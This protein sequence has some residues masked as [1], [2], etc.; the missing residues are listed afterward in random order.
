MVI[1]YVLSHPQDAYF[2]DVDTVIHAGAHLAE[3]RIYYLKS[4]LRVYWIEANPQIRKKMM[5]NIRFYSSQKGIL[6]T[7]S[8]YPGE[9]VE[10]NIANDTS[11]SSILDFNDHMVTPTHHHVEKIM[12]V[13]TSLSEL[14]GKNRIILGNRNLLLV[15]TQG[16]ELQVIKGLEEYLGKFE[17]IIA[18]SQDYELYRNQSL[19]KEIETFLLSSGFSLIKKESWAYN[20]SRSK[21]YCELV[22]ERITVNTEHT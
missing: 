14:I 11:C 20:M 21:N 6:S 9:K 3:E 13:T 17:Y 22:F 10:F 15:D 16:T 2:G 19:T 5:K 7:L 4:N 1:K 18:E 12:T 8:Q